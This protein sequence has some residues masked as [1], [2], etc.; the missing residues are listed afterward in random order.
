[1]SDDKK[2]T[3]AAVDLTGWD[4]PIVRYEPLPGQMEFSFSDSRPRLA[5]TEGDQLLLFDSGA[6]LPG[7]KDLAN[8]GQ[9]L[10]FDGED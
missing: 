10:L 7:I 8:R 6:D 1:M 3:L 9:Q 2:P 5:T 4:K